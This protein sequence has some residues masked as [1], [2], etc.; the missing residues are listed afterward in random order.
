MVVTIAGGGALI[1]E[2]GTVCV[3]VWGVHDYRVLFVG[4]G[5][6]DIAVEGVE[7]ERRGVGEGG[8]VVIEHEVIIPHT[9]H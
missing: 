3:C 4:V 5:V 7:E 8:V 2:E 6:Y 9:S 1:G